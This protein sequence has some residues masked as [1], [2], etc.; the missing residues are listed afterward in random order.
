MIHTEVSHE[1]AMKWNNC[2]N[3]SEKYNSDV[4][5][6]LLM[7]FE[8]PESRN[9]WDSPLF[10]IQVDDELPGLGICDALFHQKTPK[11]NMSTQNPPLMKTEYIYEVGKKTQDIVS[12]IFAAQKTMLIGDSVVVPGT[13]ERYFLSQTLTLSQLR[14]FRQQFLNYIKSPTTSKVDDISKTFLLFLNKCVETC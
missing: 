3:E 7:R 1:T 4:M 11:P 6:A 14:R 12:A 2:R 10:T 13:K 9:R 5:E 8:A